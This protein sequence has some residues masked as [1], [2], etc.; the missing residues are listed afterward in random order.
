MKQCL[1]VIAALLLSACGGAKQAPVEKP[2]MRVEDTVVAPLVNDLN[3]A[4]AVE[5]TLQAGKDQTDAALK[6]DE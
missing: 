1:C 6:A 5:G 2:A 3:K 4:R